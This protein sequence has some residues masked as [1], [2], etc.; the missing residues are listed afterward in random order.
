MLASG[1]ISAV[2]LDIAAAAIDELAWES[3]NSAVVDATRVRI[4][5]ERGVTAFL[6]TARMQQALGNL[7]ANAER[8][9][10][11]NTLLVAKT[12]HGALALE[13]H[14]D[15]PGVP[16]KHELMIWEKFERGSN[17]FNATVPGSGIGLAVT[18][19]IA[20]AHGGATG[21]RRSERLGGAC[22]WIRLPGRVHRE[23]N[24]LPREAS[25]NLSVV[26]N[27]RDIKSA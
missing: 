4:D 26:A 3:I 19:A 23:E 6:D 2:E 22:F 11:D 27:P 18:N 24:P 17:R 21:Y 12:N 25:L 1:S 13:V 20:Q 14:D 8:Y 5:T 9:G 16:H 10:G 15:G 7:L